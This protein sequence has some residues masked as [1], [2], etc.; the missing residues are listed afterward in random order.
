MFYI[1]HIFLKTT[2]IK[3]IHN[4]NKISSIFILLNLDIPWLNN[5]MIIV[6]TMEFLV[7]AIIG[8]T[9]A[10][11]LFEPLAQSVRNMRRVNNRSTYTNVNSFKRKI[12]RSSKIKLAR[13]KVKNRKNR[14][15]WQPEQTIATLTAFNMTPEQRAAGARP[16]KTA[17]TVCF[18][19]SYSNEEPPPYSARE[20]GS[21]RKKLKLKLRSFFKIN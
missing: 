7:L 17:N 14:M 11:V 18:N 12:K 13:P 2:S 5:L 21:R 3:T 10:S 6:L 16:H 9:Y 20:K 1:K 4:F 8:A 19:E 15:Q